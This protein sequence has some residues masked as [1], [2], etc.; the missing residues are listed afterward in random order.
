MVKKVL[1]VLFLHSLLHTAVFSFVTQHSSPLTVAENR[2]TFLSCDY[3][4]IIQLP[5]SGK[6][7][8]HICGIVTP[9]ITAL[10][11]SVPHVGMTE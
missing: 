9:P 6:C 2:T 5:F 10:F 7:L 3:P 11:L 8:R 1:A 4:I